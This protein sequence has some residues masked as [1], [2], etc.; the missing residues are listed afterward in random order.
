MEN[1]DQQTMKTIIEKHIC[2]GN[3]INADS[4]PAYNFL[5]NIDS[6]FCTIHI[7]ITEEYSDLL[8]ELR[9]YGMK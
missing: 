6:G 5:D 8:V 9:V 1:R 7:I 3:I 4:W 2:K